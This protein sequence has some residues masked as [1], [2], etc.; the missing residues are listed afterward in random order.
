VIV[1]ALDLKL[2]RLLREAMRGADA[3][4]GK[5]P[6]GTARRV[7]ARRVEPEPRIEPRHVIRPEPRFE[8]RPVVHPEPK[9]PA[10]PA[11]TAPPLEPEK[12]CKTE[13]PIRPPW[14]VLPWQTPVQ[15]APKVKLIIRR[16]DIVSKGS[17]LDFFI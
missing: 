17:L 9:L 2:V 10:A 4:A 15:P 7:L 8:P 12:P 1:A 5:G 6:L 14:K 13:S 3:A 11:P 16:P